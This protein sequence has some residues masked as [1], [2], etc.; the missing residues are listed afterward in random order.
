VHPKK[1]AWHKTGSSLKTLR[2]TWFFFF[3]FFA[4]LVGFLEFD[5]AVLN[6]ELYTLEH[7][8][9]L[10][11]CQT[12]LLGNSLIHSSSKQHPRDDHHPGRDLGISV[13]QKFQFQCGLVGSMFAQHAKGP[14][15]DPRPCTN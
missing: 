9:P 13:T 6:H 7:P 10:S 2:S 15:F 5:H 14:G 12:R 3:F 1:A 8:V 11:K 4:C